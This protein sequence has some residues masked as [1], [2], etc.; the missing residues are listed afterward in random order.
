MAAPQ[1]FTIPGETYENDG[2]E[3]MVIRNLIIP[4]RVRE[5]GYRAFTDHEIHGRIIFE[6][7]S[8]L[9]SIGQRAFEGAIRSAITLRLPASVT[10]IGDTS[11]A[12]C[13][14]RRVV[15]GAPRISIDEFAFARCRNLERVDFVDHES[16]NCKNSRTVIG[17]SAFL[18]CIALTTVNGYG[19]EHIRDRAFSGCTQL[20]TAKFVHCNIVR[21]RAFFDTHNLELILG[22][23][24]IIFMTGAFTGA[25]DLKIVFHSLYGG[26]INTPEIPHG[27]S[28]EDYLKN[29]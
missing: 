24:Y 12:K 26:S 6:G 28:Y 27:Q 13:K 3:K 11:F 8:Q 4:E 1:D 25:N 23:H 5:I 7:R 9:Q 17:Y 29:R 16:I 22:A 2:R 10:E 14:I 19:V 21:S 18:H 20:R 15:F